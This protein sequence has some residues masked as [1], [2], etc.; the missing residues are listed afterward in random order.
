MPPAESRYFKDQT[1]AA[2]EEDINHFQTQGNILLVGDMNAHTAAEL[3]T[4]N[5]EGD[6]YMN[7]RTNTCLTL[8]PRNNYDKMTNKHGK[9]LLQL[10]RA[11]SLYIVNGRIRGDSFGRYTYS[12]SLG[13]STLDY[14]ITDLDSFSFSAFTVKQQ[15]PFSGHNQINIY[16]KRTHANQPCPNPSKLYNITT[17]YRWEQNRLSEY[18]EAMSSHGNQEHLNAFLVHTYPH[19]KEGV[20]VA[21]KHINNIF[22]YVAQQSNLPFLKQNPKKVKQEKWYDSECKNIRKLLR[23]LSNQKHRDPENQDLRF[24]YSDTLKQYKQ[25]LRTK[26]EQHHKKQVNLIEESINSNSFC[27][28]WKILNKSNNNNNI[29]IQDGD[30]WIKHFK[31]LYQTTSNTPEQDQKQ[32]KLNQLETIIKD[33][34]NLD[35]EITKKELDKKFKTLKCRKACGPDS[36][37]NEML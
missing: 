16:L 14:T 25:T 30:I 2:L 3:D 11:L 28:H 22:H 6:K 19:S 9:E 7:N 23:Q 12:S 36:I 17:H 27:D 32:E 1:F 34:Q 4:T 15:T 21:T 35:Y 37:V 8:P 20:N 5:T 10:C 29:A 26:K 33:Y 24:H 13:S 31:D 18:Q